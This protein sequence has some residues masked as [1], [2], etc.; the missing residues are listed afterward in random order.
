[1]FERMIYNA[2]L[3]HLDMLEKK[4]K[5]E[6][7]EKKSVDSAKVKSE[8]RSASNFKLPYSAKAIQQ[9]AS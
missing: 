4:I 2:K 3:I 7:E 9:T 8:Y 1:M 5:N 6:A